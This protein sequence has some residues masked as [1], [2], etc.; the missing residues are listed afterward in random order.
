PNYATAHQWYAEYLAAMGR[1]PEACAEIRRASET[2]PL[3]LIV[4]AAEGYI[5]Y[6]GRDFDETIRHSEK[7]L[8]MDPDFVPAHWFLGWGYVQKR[9]FAQA[10]ATF[11]KAVSLSGG[12]SWML[13]DLGHAYAVSG[14]KAKAREIVHQLEMKSRQQYVSPYELALVYVGLNEKE[15]ALVWLRKAFEDR[16][17]QLIYLRVES[18]LDHLRADSRFTDLLRDVGLAP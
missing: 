17:W 7:A 11:E 2:D 3:S 13:A 15:R 8:E 14:R 10:V 18:K 5:R 4:T 12:N 6:F 9:M 16:A 1:Q